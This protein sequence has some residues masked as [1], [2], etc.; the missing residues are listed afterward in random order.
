MN[1][2]SNEAVIDVLCVTVAVVAA[3]AAIE[4]I[5]FTLNVH[6][7]NNDMYSLLRNI[8]QCLSLIHSKQSV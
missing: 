5:S 7:T 3:S 8:S 6:I 4:T 1:V 2:C